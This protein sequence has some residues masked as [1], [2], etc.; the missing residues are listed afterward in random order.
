MDRNL[1]PI[2]VFK[3]E[4]EMEPFKSIVVPSSMR[5]PFWKYFGFPANENKEIITKMKVVCVICYSY[6][7]YNKNTTNLSTHLNCKHPDVKAEI[8]AAKR[9][10]DDVSLK[11]ILTMSAAK[12]YKTKDDMTVNWFVDYDDDEDVEHRYKGFERKHPTGITDKSAIKSKAYKP[13]F[14]TV[15]ISNENILVVKS[16]G[17]SKTL[18]VD[19]EIEPIEHEQD[20]QFMESIDYNNIDINEEGN[21]MITE[22]L[23]TDSTANPHPSKDDYLSEEF[24]NINE[25]HEDLYQR[26]EIGRFSSK[27]SPKPFN[28]P[29]LRRDQVIEL[30]SEVTHQVKQFLIQD[31]V[32]SHV[33][34]GTGFKELLSFLS[35][36]VLIPSSLEVSQQQRFDHTRTDNRTFI[37][38]PDWKNHWRRIPFAKLKR[39]IRN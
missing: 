15:S 19:I 26:K 25:P 18:E 27:S 12:K 5:S 9:K 1:K 23:E 13:K 37:S 7:A 8:D 31:L 34:D 17:E 21:E 3:D 35:P 20:D 24:L 4:R 30:P 11:D 28:K 38:I 10:Q 2:L 6:I 36:N 29:N 39:H 14:Q 32:P 16:E 33:I 22:I